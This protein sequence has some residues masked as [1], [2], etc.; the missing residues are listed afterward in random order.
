[1]ADGG[2]AL[3]G[4]QRL[5]EDRTQQASAA[6]QALMQLQQEHAQLAAHMRNAQDQ[7]AARSVL[8]LLCNLLCKG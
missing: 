1:M 4:M 3:A 6:Q 7:A 2:S 8:M 5:V